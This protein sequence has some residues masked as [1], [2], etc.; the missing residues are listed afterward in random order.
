MAHI[1]DKKQWWAANFCTPHIKCADNSFFGLGLGVGLVSILILAVVAVAIIPHGH[2]IGVGGIL[3][4]DSLKQNRAN[5]AEEAQA[6]YAAADTAKRPPTAEEKKSF[7]TLMGEV[8]SLSERITAQL[9]IEAVTGDV[10]RDTVPAAARPQLD[11][12]NATID[13]GQYRSRKLAFFKDEKT[14]YDCGMWIIA[15]LFGKHYDHA[16]SE[17]A[18]HTSA[19]SLITAARAYAQANGMP[20]RM[21]QDSANEGT[22]SQG[23][24]LVP[25]ALESTII[26]LRDAY[27][28]VRQ[29]CRVMPMMSNYQTQPKRLTGLTAYAVA[30]GTAPTESQKG[31]GRVALTARKWAVLTRYS[32]EIAE[33]AVINIA[34]DLA[35]E[36]A[37]A[38]AVAE[39]NALFIGDGTSTYN[40]IVGLK[41]RFTDAD[42]NSS[43]GAVTV[44]TSTHDLFAEVDADDIDLLMAA[45]PVYARR[46]AQFYIGPQGKSLIFDPL[47]RSAGGNTQAD[48]AN[49]MPPR[50]MGCPINEVVAMSEA[51][52]TV[53]DDVPILYYGR[54]DLATEMGTR[55]GITL[56]TSTDIYFTTDEIAIR[57]TERFDINIHSIGDGTTAG[58]L[59][60]LIGETS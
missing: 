20:L 40:G 9:R 31:W 44:A 55:R 43:V 8:D 16:G 34:M 22:N 29:F 26:D 2:M 38:F 30:E 50:Y 14:A 5:K 6:I 17:L 36:I 52:S 59:V 42:A 10:P 13:Y 47:L 54:M 39:D 25:V 18:E 49:G 32:S 27:G 24:Y 37:Y 53:H 60:A 23:G 48:V 7:D 11:K 21:V 56:A 58:P 4:S 45:L 15:S 28:V 41:R 46:G 35:Q 51:S 57:G 1:K 33:D 3:V 19:K 12:P